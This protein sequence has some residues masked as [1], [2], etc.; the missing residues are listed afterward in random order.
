[1]SN[2]CTI[3]CEGTCPDRQAKAPTFCA[4]DPTESGTRG[5]CVSKSSAG[6]SNCGDMPGTVEADSERFI[7]GSS[8]SQRSAT[9][10]LPKTE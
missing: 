8:A 5:I 1:L 9:V 10:C 2:F 6:N 7:G 4:P 3:N